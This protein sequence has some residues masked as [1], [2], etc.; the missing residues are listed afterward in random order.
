MLNQALESE[1]VA[2]EPLMEA[3]TN[4]AHRMVSKKHPATDEIESKLNSLLADL[5]ELK[6]LTTE[7]RL[8]LTSAVE[9]QMVGFF[10]EF[11]RSVQNSRLPYNLYCVG[12]DIKHCS[13]QSN[14]G[15]SGKSGN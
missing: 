3:V 15:R 9:S 12:G 7:R 5:R 2:H 14:R 1:I 8:K 13:I 4:M 6:D 11:P 10:P